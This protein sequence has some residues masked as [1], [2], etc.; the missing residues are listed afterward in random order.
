[1]FKVNNKNVRIRFYL[2]LTLNMQPRGIFRTLCDRLPG[3]FMALIDLIRLKTRR[4]A[5]GCPKID[6][7]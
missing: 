2:S 1:M 5:F 3:S 7:E 6:S 4:A